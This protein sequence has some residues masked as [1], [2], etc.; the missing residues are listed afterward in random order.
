MCLWHEVSFPPE[1]VNQERA[2]WKQCLLPSSLGRNSLSF[3]QDPIQNVIS[4]GSDT[5]MIL[6]QFERGLKLIPGER[7]LLRAF[8]DWPFHIFSL[9]EKL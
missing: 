4:T 7:K 2:R 3:L 8:R 9:I 1:L 6:I 5:K